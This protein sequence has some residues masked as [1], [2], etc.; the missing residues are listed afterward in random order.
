MSSVN[1]SYVGMGRVVGFALA[2][3]NYEIDPRTLKELDCTRRLALFYDAKA[4]DRKFN[5]VKKNTR[6]GYDTIYLPNTIALHSSLPSD[7]TARAH[8][9]RMVAGIDTDACRKL[10][11]CT[12]RDQVDKVTNE[13]VTALRQVAR[14]AG[15]LWCRWKNSARRVSAEAATQAPARS[16]RS[17]QEKVIVFGTAENRA[18]PV[19]YRRRDLVATRNTA[20]IVTDSKTTAPNHSKEYMEIL[21][22][23][24]LT[25]PA[26]QH[27]APDA[28]ETGQPSAHQ[29]RPQPQQ[30]AAW[31]WSLR[32]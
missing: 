5:K 14:T 27:P 24:E 8:W 28:A 17:S 10:R 11:T 9:A 29:A 16:S 23:I 18:P 13:W 3:L 15:R 22:E 1:L 2:M 25:L 4:K 6:C 32:M 30:Y 7:C 12:T 21:D 26:D 20:A 31:N 19:G